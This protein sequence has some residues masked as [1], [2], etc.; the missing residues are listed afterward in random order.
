MNGWE[1][2][3]R[4]LRIRS[5]AILPIYFPGDLLLALQIQAEREQRS[6]TE[7]AAE[8]LGDMLASRRVVD[9]RILIWE[10]LSGRQ[11]E[12]VAMLCLNYSNPKIA[13][14]LGISINAVKRHVQKILE[15]FAVH[16]RIELRQELAHWDFSA[17][18]GSPAP[19]IPEINLESENP[20]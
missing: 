1:H 7:L 6:A 15:R 5:P 11:Q 18:P 13:S 14:Y 9:E 2:L 19:H 8:L 12:I 3:L 20:P 17:W 4:G 10:A 16:D